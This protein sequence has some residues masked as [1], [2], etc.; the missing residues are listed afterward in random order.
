MFRKEPAMRKQKTFTTYLTCPEC[1]MEF[2]IQRR[3]GRKRKANHIKDL[4][5]PRCGKI[6]KFEESRY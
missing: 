4:W 3:V 5:C 2:P 6:C 1:G